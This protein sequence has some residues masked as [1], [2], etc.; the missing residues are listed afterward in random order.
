LQ[1]T[2]DPQ[3]ELG[4]TTDPGRFAA[5]LGDLG[6]F[7]R[8]EQFQRHQ[9]GI[10]V[11]GGP[12]QA[13]QAGLLRLNLNPILASPEPLSSAEFGKVLSERRAGGVSPLFGFQQGADAP[14]SP[15]LLS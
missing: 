14:R 4:Q 11:H 1:T 6:P 13:L 5:N 10:D 2:A 3:A 7:S 12:R 9:Q 8:L 15:F